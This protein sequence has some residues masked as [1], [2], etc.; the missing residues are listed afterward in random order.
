M[1]DETVD[2]KN[3]EAALSEINFCGKGGQRNRRLFIEKCLLGGSQNIH[4]PFS[5][6]G[7]MLG[8]LKEEVEKNGERLKDKKIAVLFNVEFIEVLLFDFGIDP[9]NIT[10]FADSCPEWSYVYAAYGLPVTGEEVRNVYSKNMLETLEKINMKFD[11]VVG[12]PPYQS[13]VKKSDSIW[14]FFV[15]KATELVKDNGFVVFVNPC[16]WRK[17]EHK[18]FKIFQNNYLRYLEIHNQKDGIKT[19][20]AGTRYDWYILQKNNSGMSN[21][22]DEFGEKLLLDLK[23][24][25]CLPNYNIDKFLSF[26]ARN[27][28]PTCRLIYSRSAYGHDKPHMC[29]K[30]NDNNIFPCVNATRND[31]LSLIYSNTDKNGHFGV[32][33]FIMGIVSPEN[34]FFDKKGEYGVT[35][36]SFA[37]GVDSEEDGL[38]IGKA[39]KTE[40][41]S[42]F[43]FSCKWSGMA[44]DP[45]VFKYFCKDFWENFV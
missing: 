17:P 16:S 20:G 40:Q 9:K 18:L 44:F 42:N 36:N 19:F 27:N 12:N 4:T 23:K 32:S 37:I 35:D 26:L 1:I 10:F 29:D 7:E 31:G 13:P 41:F 28:E 30:K 14:K 34:G 2:M 6:C 38:V 25:P 39:I 43:I 24:T 5:L 3:L 33:K 11:V 21:I 8:K 15:I 45:T 22:V